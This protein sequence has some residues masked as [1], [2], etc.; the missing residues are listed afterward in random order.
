MQFPGIDRLTK[1]CVNISDAAPRF[2]ATELAAAAIRSALTLALLSALQ[3]AT[4]PAQAQT[5]TVLY[6]FTGGPD[7]GGPTGNLTSDGKGNFYG[8][9]T[10]GGATGYGSVFEL[11]PNGSGGWNGN[12]V[13]SFCS[14]PSCADGDDPYLTYVLFD[15]LGNLYGTTLYG[16]AYGHGVVFELIPGAGSSWTETVLYGFTGGADG[17]N[18]VNGLVMDQGGNLYGTTHNLSNQTGNVFELSPSEG[19]WTEQVIYSFNDSTFAGLTMDAAKQNIFGVTYS[20]VFELSPNGSGGLNSNVI[21]T[22][23]GGPKDGSDPQG[24]PAVD[25]AGNVY[26]T[27]QGGGADYEGTVYKLSAGTA[28]TE[29]ILYSFPGGRGGRTPEAGIVF[30]TAGNIY[31]TTATGGKYCEIAKKDDLGCGTV[32][33]LVAPVG[34]KTT[35]KEKTL[36]NFNGPDGSGPFSGVILDAG[37]LYGM[38][39]RGGIDG[40]YIEG[41]G[42][43]YQVTP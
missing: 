18:P 12:V 21:H 13:Y 40:G 28:W 37:N 33:E 7:G 1:N 5:E 38:T 43:V 27:T 26:G 10:G 17:S 39:Y 4:C 16:G 42:V 6:D 22:F 8:T 30:D 20:T 36:W 32:F 15:S 41:P 23:A 34:K 14:A 35:Y 11:S 31:G 29:Q 2:S 3:F 25:K 9:T 19:G 24:T